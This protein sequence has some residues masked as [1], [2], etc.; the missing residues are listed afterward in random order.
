MD[1]LLTCRTCSIQLLD[2][3]RDQALWIPRSTQR[4]A[5][6]TGAYTFCRMAAMAAC[7][8]QQSTSQPAAAVV[9][10]ASQASNG[11][12]EP[13][14]QYTEDAPP[15][16]SS[17]ATGPTA[18][19]PGQP[20]G[21][22]AGA[23]RGVAPGSGS[24]LGSAAAGTDGAQ[25]VNAAAPRAGGG[26]FA[27]AAGAPAA[28]EP[29]R[30][31]IGIVACPGEHPGRVEIWNVQVRCRLFCLRF[32]AC[33]VRGATCKAKHRHI[34]ECATTRGLRLR[35]ALWRHVRHTAA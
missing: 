23:G 25:T 5:F 26:R 27:P 28:V 3:T 12:T 22:T 20:A 17:A 34:S 18:G 14:A 33:S 11:A 32:K 4:A 1:T 21:R 8:A 2:F 16:D 30:D 6:C 35:A 10:P 7:D 19:G 29:C 9:E 31:A 13:A 24:P 15:G